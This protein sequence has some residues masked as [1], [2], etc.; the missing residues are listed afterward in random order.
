MFSIKITLQENQKW[1]SIR[2][3]YLQ[4]NPN[5]QENDYFNEEEKLSAK[6]LLLDMTNKLDAMKEDIYMKHKVF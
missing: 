1:M 5:E 4:D 6:I 2:R 3:I